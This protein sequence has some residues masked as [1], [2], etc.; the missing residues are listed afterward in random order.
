MTLLSCISRLASLRLEKGREGRGYC[1][2][3]CIGGA[4]PW[5]DPESGKAIV[6]GSDS[7][8]HAAAAP[9]FAVP[10]CVGE[11]AVQRPLWMRLHNA[12]DESMFCVVFRERFF[13]C[14]GDG[15]PGGSD[16]FDFG[17]QLAKICLADSERSL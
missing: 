10:V 14:R 7:G 6:C 8:H 15:Y 12:A 1:G 3:A 9:D 2:E 16:M 17:N 5:G 13:A 4:C 11:A